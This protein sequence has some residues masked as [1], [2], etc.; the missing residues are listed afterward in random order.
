MQNQEIRDAAKSK[1]IHLWQ[2]ADALGIN[3]GNLSRRLRHELPES[4]KTEI[5]KI[6]QQLSEQK[7][8]G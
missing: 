7:E 8:K 5:R 6:I 1:G 4:Q 3:D 2:I